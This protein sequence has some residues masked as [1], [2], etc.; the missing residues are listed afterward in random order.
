[1]P[2]GLSRQTPATIA[3]PCPSR[4]HILRTAAAASVLA[5]AFTAVRTAGATAL[6]QPA[7]PQDEA[8]MRQTI[9]IARQAGKRFAALIVGDGEVIATGYNPGRQ[10]G[11]IHDPTAHGEMVA[12]HSCITER[13]AEALRGATLYTTGESCPMCMSA[14]VWCHMG[15]VVYGVSIEKLATKMSQIMIPCAEVADRSSFLDI[16][17]TGG[18]LET[19]AWALFQ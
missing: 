7:T 9:D 18:V 6:T 3:S 16:G 13:G 19:E 10:D 5:P 14:I 17:V 1:M 15:R 8:F 2:S 4:R 11:V 12:I